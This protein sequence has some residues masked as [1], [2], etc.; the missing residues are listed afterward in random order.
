M[1]A[2]SFLR[3]DNI[4]SS[5]SRDLRSLQNPDCDKMQRSLYSFPFIG[6]E[7]RP[8]YGTYGAGQIPVH[9]IDQLNTSDLGTAKTKMP[10]DRIGAVEA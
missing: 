3:T 10:L 4:G 8:A 9:P 7:E 2:A 5:I 1:S 6:D